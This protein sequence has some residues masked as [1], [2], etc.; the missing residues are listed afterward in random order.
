MAEAPSEEVIAVSEYPSL[1]VRLWRRGPWRSSALMRTSDRIQGLVGIC[2][3]VAVLFAVPVACAA[4]TAG[5]SAAAAR[6]EAESATKVEL[7][8]T[9]VS[10]PDRILSASRYPTAELGFEARVRWIRNGHD[11]TAVTGVPAGSR[12]GAEVPIWLSAD[13]EPTTAPPGSDTAISS[14]VGIGLMLLSAVWG[15]ALTLVWVTGRLLDAHRAGSWARE[16][17]Q[18]CRQNGYLP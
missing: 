16:W 13:G 4:G 10:E 12:I 11:R 18:I 5:Y 14:G 1:P 15:A 17:N 8:A 2:A 7:T 3:A 6:V 9:V